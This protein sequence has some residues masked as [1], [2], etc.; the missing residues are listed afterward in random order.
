MALFD[1]L[2]VVGEIL[3]GGNWVTGLAI[4]VGAVSSCHSRL[5]SSAPWRKLRSGAA[6]WPTRAWLDWPRASA[7]LSPR[8]RPRAEGKL[9]RGRW[10]AQRRRPG[11][12]GRSAVGVRTEARV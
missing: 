2:P 4:G 10:K 9:P 1:D 11:R 3:G 5:Q 6:F 8:L 12:C 7:I